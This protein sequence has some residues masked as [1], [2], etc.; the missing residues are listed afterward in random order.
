MRKVIAALAAAGVL[1][2]G[3]FTAAAVSSPGSAA[4]QE[5]PEDAVEAPERPGKGQ[6]M[7]D[8]LNGLVADNVITQDQADQIAT[9]FEEAAAERREEFG[10][11]G[12]RGNRR[13]F[14][15]GSDLRGLLEDGVIDADE[16]AELGPDHPLN[17]PDGPAADFVEDGLT[18][19][20]LQ[21]IRQQLHDERRA[22]SEGDADAASLTV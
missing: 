9:A 7:E 14:R 19:D 15:G 4:A 6:F 17:D 16:L 12:H 8:V 2:A 3:A 10:D 18:M 22:Q 11:R 5:T 20:E 1:V 13:G 21:E